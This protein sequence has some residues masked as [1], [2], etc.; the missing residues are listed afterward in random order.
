M[1]LNQEH[2]Y[3]IQQKLSFT[4]LVVFGILIVVLGFLQMRNTIYTPFVIRA[5]DL[6]DPANAALF[7]N[8]QVKL[9]SID[10]D[11]D[12]LN[13]YEE[14]QFFGTSPYLPD[15]DSD[16]IA[17]K[18]EIDNHT[19][20]LCPEGK[21]CAT[22]ATST[23]TAQG[24]TPVLGNETGIGQNPTT[25]APA[26]ILSNLSSLS[27]DPQALRAMMLKTGSLSK[28]DLDKVDDAT[29]LQ[30]A[31]NLISQQFGAGTVAS[32]STSTP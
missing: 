4:M 11:H 23:S 20:P 19:D 32:S 6:A 22:E 7:E 13:D 30:L 16:G 14:L 24:I 28:E 10:T 29:I 2:R 3:T 12:G 17:D 1:D 5:S 8:D 26:S 9:Q 27:Q 25:P 18:V 15:S 21:K 31:Q